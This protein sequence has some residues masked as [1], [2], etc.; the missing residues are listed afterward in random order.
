MVE[1]HRPLREIPPL[2]DPEAIDRLMR[3]PT[4]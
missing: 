4:A 1:V 2:A 3:A